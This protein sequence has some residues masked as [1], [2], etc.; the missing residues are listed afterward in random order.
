MRSVQKIKSP[1]ITFQGQKFH[2]IFFHPDFTVGS[3]ISPDRANGSQTLTAGRES[4][5]AP[6]IILFNYIVSL[7]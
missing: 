7:H 1:K 6:K 2:L 5:P 3:G 4:N